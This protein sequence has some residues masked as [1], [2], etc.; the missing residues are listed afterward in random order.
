MMMNIK[1]TIQ[2]L[3][4]EFDGFVSELEGWFSPGFDKYNAYQEFTENFA[5][6]PAEADEREIDDF[7]KNVGSDDEVFKERIRKYR[8]IL[9][10]PGI[11]IKRVPASHLGYGILGRCFPYAGLIEIRSDLYG[12][13][14][15]EVLTHELTHMHNPHL[16]ELEVRMATRMKLSFIPKW[17]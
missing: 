3:Q 17:H 13:D 8:P 1:D 9:V 2:K 4:L 16:G 11:E 7:F 14:F 15:T 10:Y 5:I 6:D 12:E